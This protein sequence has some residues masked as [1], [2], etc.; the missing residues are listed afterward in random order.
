LTAIRGGIPEAQKWFATGEAIA[1]LR[2]LERKGAI[3]RKDEETTT[4]FS[5]NELSAVDA[6]WIGDNLL[7]TGWHA[8]V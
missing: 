1:H 6:K 3:I 8:A 7:T 2:Y 4:K 5:L